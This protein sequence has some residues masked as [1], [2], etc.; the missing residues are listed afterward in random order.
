[1]PALPLGQA[2]I[3]QR[4]GGRLCFRQFLENFR[5]LGKP[6]RAAEFQPLGK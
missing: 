1:M 2:Q 5:R 4:A 6:A 3:H